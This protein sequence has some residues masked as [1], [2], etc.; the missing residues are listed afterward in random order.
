MVKSWREDY[1]E[2]DNRELRKRLKACIELI[3]ELSNLEQ[4]LF[5]ARLD[6]EFKLR[7]ARTVGKAKVI[8]DKKLPKK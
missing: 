4:P 6:L 8:L 2:E 1:L 3:E 7:Y 5:E